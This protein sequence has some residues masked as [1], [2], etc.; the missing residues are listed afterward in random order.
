MALELL[1][2][3]DLD[4]EL[5]L[6]GGG[7][8]GVEGDAVGVAA[9]GGL[10]VLPESRV[11]PDEAQGVDGVV[12][13]HLQDVEGGAGVGVGALGLNLVEKV[14]SDVL[15]VR[16]VEGLGLLV[17]ADDL[18]VGGQ[19]ER[20]QVRD[21]LVGDERPD[22]VDEELGGLGQD[23]VVGPDAVGELSVGNVSLQLNSGRDVE[24]WKSKKEKKTQ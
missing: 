11:G 3:T 2:E 22:V 4:V 5:E 23:L 12:V 1:A 9:D 16:E 19:G 17:A 13:E 14:E 10:A 6:L 18:H 20:G 8:G 15:S 24:D 7:G 21:L